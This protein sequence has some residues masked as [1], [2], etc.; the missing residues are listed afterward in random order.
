[1]NKIITSLLFI[2]SLANANA[3]LQFVPD[4][5]YF[6]MEVDLGKIVKSISLEEINKLE[7][8]KNVLDGINSSNEQ[9]NFS[10]LGIDFNS[11]L[12]AYTAEKESCSNTT[13]IIPIKDR[14]SFIQLF[15]DSDQFALKKNNLIIKN[16][17]IISINKNTCTITDLE[18]KNSYFSNII[19][20]LYNDKG[21]TL[22]NNFYYMYGYDYIDFEDIYYEEE[23]YFDE[24][25]Y[26]KAEDAEGVEYEDYDAAEDFSEEYED[27]L[28]EDNQEELEARLREVMDSIKNV[29]KK[30]FIEEYLNFLENPKNN[31]LSN[32][33]VFKNA[34]SQVADAKLYFNPSAN[35]EIY[36][37]LYY[38]PFGS[39]IHQELDEFRQF[40]YLNFSPEGIQV[41]WKVKTS[42]NFGKA[43]NKA[44][45]GKLNKQLLK[46]IP[47]YAQGFAIYNVNTFG[48]YE[49]LKETYL[50]IL[51][52]SEDG[53][54]VLA[55][56]IWSTIDEF[57]NMEAISSI[58]PPQLLFSYGGL[59]EIELPKVTYEYDEESFQY[60]E[61]DTSYLEKIPMVNIVLLNE[62]A[63]LLEKYFNAIMKLEEGLILKTGSY[64]TVLED[65]LRIG[66][67]YY[68][69]IIDDVILITNDED[70]V[71]Y[72]LNGFSNK[73]FD[74]SIYKKAKKAKLFYAHLDLTKINTDM[75][76]IY[77]RTEDMLVRFED[78]TAEIDFEMTSISKDQINFKVQMKTN[79][80]YKNGAHFLFELI[81]DVYLMNK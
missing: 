48:A 1:M 52:A 24:E 70:I 23:V 38:N 20:D 26:E 25:I 11:K 8:T 56:A 69:A 61:V 35:P 64:Y 5:V 45:S 65:P 78:K 79:E 40:A 34:S 42:E 60:S 22:P 50:P 75:A 19:E 77:G 7:F 36:R 15:D 14:N 41:D 21:W 13:V 58:Y 3:Q 28:S 18:W 63:Y 6:V 81:N 30:L 67:P 72:N 66:I 49:Q 73:A 39:F 54:E 27:Y 71:N 32:D 76:N 74:K 37:D 2:F 47:D 17:L 59:K 43:M 46:Y 55:G 16:D 12:L 44:A 31:L 53:K 29:E 80:K 10:D 68:I 33:R 57:I 51:D 62:R 9:L 4:S